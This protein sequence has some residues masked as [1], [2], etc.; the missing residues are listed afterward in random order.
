MEPVSEK[1][2]AVRALCRTH[3]VE[4][5]FLFGSAATG[6]FNPSSSD[7]DFLVVFKPF[8]RT[9]WNDHF[10][11]LRQGLSDLFRREVDLVEAHTLRNPYLIASTNQSKRML[12][13]A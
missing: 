13:A 4:R 5:L 11:Q 1:I 12:Y 9:G 3:E 2:E 6:R 10:F 8:E 7:L